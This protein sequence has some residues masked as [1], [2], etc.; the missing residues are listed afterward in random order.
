MQDVQVGDTYHWEVSGG[1]VS[2]SA[3]TGHGE[4]FVNSWSIVKKGVVTTTE[5]NY[6]FQ[7]LFT[8]QCQFVY[9]DFEISAWSP[10]S[11]YNFPVVEMNTDGEEVV[12]AHSNRILLTIPT[13]SS[14]VTRIRIAAKESSEFA[15]RLIAEVDKDHLGLGN[16]T[17]HIYEFLN[18]SASLF[19]EPLESVKLFDSVPLLSQSQ[20]FASDRIMDGLITEGFDQIELDMR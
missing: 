15:Y 11:R 6:L 14:I 12:V 2:S 18:S 7:R 13:G 5:P 17:T 20:E 9:D 19:L 10:I 4:V 8:F 3:K 1:G 16:N